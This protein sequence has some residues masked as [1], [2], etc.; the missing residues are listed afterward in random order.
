MPEHMRRSRR[1]HPDAARESLSPA[2]GWAIGRVAVEVSPDSHRDSLSGARAVR[3]FEL[4]QAAVLA[5]LLD[6]HID[7]VDA[8]ELNREIAG[9]P[10]A[11]FTPA[12]VADAV[13][14]LQRVGLVQGRGKALAPTVAARRCQRLLERTR[15][16]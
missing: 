16:Q 14:E 15:S 11:F 1:P 7:G 2:T 3:E 5:Y 13:A 9:A 4:V 6:G 10:E 8:G 12:A